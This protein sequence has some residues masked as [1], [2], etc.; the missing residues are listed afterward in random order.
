M[1]LTKVIIKKEIHDLLKRMVNYG[2]CIPLA[3][4]VL[5]IFFEDE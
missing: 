5:L 4:E 3:L 2:K 1:A